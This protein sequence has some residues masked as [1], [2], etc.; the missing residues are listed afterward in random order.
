MNNPTKLTQCAT[1]G[2]IDDLK[3]FPHVNGCKCRIVTDAAHP[4]MYE[5]VLSQPCMEE[6]TRHRGT[7]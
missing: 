1:G 5:F 7:E 3:P 2:L 6:L 4:A